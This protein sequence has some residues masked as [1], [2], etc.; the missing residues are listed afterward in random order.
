MKLIVIQYN[1]FIVVVRKILGVERGGDKCT[2]S[3]T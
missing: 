3:D 2:L 1:I